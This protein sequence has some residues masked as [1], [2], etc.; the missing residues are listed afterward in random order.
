MITLTTTSTNLFSD[1]TAASPRHEASCFSGWHS[2]PY[3]WLRHLMRHP[4]ARLFL[5]EDAGDMHHAANAAVTLLR[6]SQWGRHADEVKLKIVVKC[7]APRVGRLAKSS[8]PVAN[9][10]AIGEY[11]VSRAIT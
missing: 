2:K 9:A 7:R 6:Y 5:E 10:R 1:S 8:V 4:R 3:R 11:R